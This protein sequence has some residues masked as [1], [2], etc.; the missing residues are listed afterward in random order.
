MCRAGLRSGDVVTRIVVLLEQPFQA[1]F[2]VVTREAGLSLDLGPQR[3]TEPALPR[4][5]RCELLVRCRRPTSGPNHPNVA[6]GTGQ[7]LPSVVDD[8]GLRGRNGQ[9]QNQ[10]RASAPADQRLVQGVLLG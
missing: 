3:A 6:A 5:P 9:W 10:P 4:G 7:L 1:G 8:A 2:R